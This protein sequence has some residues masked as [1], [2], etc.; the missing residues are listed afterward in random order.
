MGITIQ[1]AL[2]LGVLI[3]AIILFSI[4]K[5]PAEVTALGLLLFLVLTNL[6]PAE[7]AFA[8]FSSDVVI[9]MFGLLILMAALER[10]GVTDYVR[11]LILRRIDSSPLQLLILVMVAAVTIGAFMSNT[12]ATAFFLP[13][14]IGLARRQKLSPAKFLMPLAFASILASS[15]TLIGTSTNIVVSGMM[16]NYGLQAIRMFELTPV[17]LPIAA[18]GLLYMIL[19]G[20][21]LVPDRIPPDEMI[22]STRLYLSE[23]LVPK[24]SSLVGQTLS[25]ARLG[26]DL[27]LK[28]LRIVREGSRY[29]IPRAVT[30]LQAGDVLLVE[31]KRANILQVEERE[32]VDIR[33]E[34]KFS[35]PDL[36]SGDIALTE[37]ILL[38]GSP[39][40]GRTL[41]G[42]NFRNRYN[43]QVLAINHYSEMFVR[44]MSQIRLRTADV[45]VVQGDHQ[46]I[47][48]LER[49]GLFRILGS[50]DKS[51]PKRK[52]APIA[53]GIFVGVLAMMTFN[54]LSPA[55]AML[56]GALLVLATRCITPGEA[57]NR[58]NWTVLLIIAAML[59]L[60]AAMETTGTAHFLASQVTRLVG[61]SNPV[62]LLSV[63]FLMTVLLTQPMSNQAAAAVVLPVAIQTAEQMTLNPRPF[64]I[65]IALAASCSFLTPLEPACLLVYGPGHYQFSDFPKVGLILSV[66]VY[67]IAILLTPWLWPF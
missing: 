2:L 39:L 49:Q 4:E 11:R 52:R 27:D 31:G 64:A 28:V 54:L 50:E 63:F 30:Q 18:V 53:M 65:I 58:I 45:L 44:K 56:L 67:L 57:Y 66:L 42:V 37:V 9:M 32:G 6:L 7:Q 60:G 5:I 13:I 17:G 20:R 38:P 62:L 12:A 16:T 29:V 23:I 22:D 24:D 19:L 14:V 33:A 51:R 21:H 61:A 55:V 25:Q 1:I 3:A 47:E 59:G 36:E 34:V 48:M 15:I 26:S 43:L 10:T 8:G 35:I 40:I 46:Q 41:K